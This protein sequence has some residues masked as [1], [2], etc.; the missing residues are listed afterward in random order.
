VAGLVAGTAATA[1]T[2]VAATTEA[3]PTP[4]TDPLDLLTGGDHHRH[5]RH[6]KRDRDRDRDKRSEREQRID[7][8]RHIALNQ[9]GDPYEY[10]AAG[11]RRF[12]CSGLIYYSYRKAGFHHVPRTSDGQADHARRIKK[13]ELRHGDFMFFADGGGVYHAGI[14]LR[15]EHGD[16]LM[17]HSPEEGERV[18]RENPWTADWYAGTLRGL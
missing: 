9:I 13:K 18:H 2:A 8:A 5:H 1:P 4:D 7:E 3:A 15:W 11:P 16:A 14:F 10:G 17:L 6:H 12:D